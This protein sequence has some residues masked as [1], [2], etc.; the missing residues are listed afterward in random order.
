MKTSERVIPISS[1]SVS[2]SL[3]ARPTNG[4]PCS[5]SLAPGASPTNISSASAFPAP[6]TTVLRVAASSGQRRQPCACANTSLRASRRSEADRSLSPE[7]TGRMVVT[8][9]EERQ[10]AAAIGSAAPACPPTCPAQ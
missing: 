1:S 5:S 9:H 4:S 8:P 2:R 6:N 10:V 7:D 3:P